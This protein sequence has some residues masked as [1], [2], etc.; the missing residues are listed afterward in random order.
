MRRTKTLRDTIEGRIAR[1]CGDDVFLPREFRDLG[2]EDEVLRVMRI[3]VRERPAC[4]RA[5]QGYALDTGRA[6]LPNW[7]P[8]E[9]RI[10]KMDRW[11]PPVR[12]SL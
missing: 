9:R 3:L 11:Q 6:E 10:Q 1:K 5:E 7:R 12:L 2:G 4:D 8:S